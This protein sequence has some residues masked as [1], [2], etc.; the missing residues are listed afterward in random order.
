MVGTGVLLESFPFC[1]PL[2]T[3]LRSVVQRDPSQTLLAA[4]VLS[5]EQRGLVL[6]L[7]PYDEPPNAPYGTPFEWNAEHIEALGIRPAWK[8]SVERKVNRPAPP[9]DTL[10]H[11]AFQ[12]PRPVDPSD[13]VPMAPPIPQG[14]S[15]LATNAA[16]KAVQTSLSMAPDPTG[17]CVLL[18][19][20]KWKSK[21]VPPPTPASADAAA[22][23][24]PSVKMKAEPPPPVGLELVHEVAAPATA[25]VEG[26][27]RRPRL[28]KAKVYLAEG[29]HTTTQQSAEG[30]PVTHAHAQRPTTH[31]HPRRPPGPRHDFSPPRAAVHTLE[32]SADEFGAPP[33]TRQ[34]P[35]QQQ[36]QQQQRQ[37]Q[38]PPR[39]C[40][41]AQPTRKRATYA[42]GVRVGTKGTTIGPPSGPPPVRPQSAHALHGSATTASTAIGA[43]DAETAAL[44]HAVARAA[45]GAAA[46]ERAAELE[47]GRP[48]TM[49]GRPGATRPTATDAR[50]ARRGEPPRQQQLDGD[51]SSLLPAAGMWWTR[52]AK[53]APARGAHLAEL[54]EAEALAA[55]V[56]DAAD[57]D[58]CGEWMDAMPSRHS[59]PSQ[60][61]YVRLAAAMQA[62]QLGGGGGGGGRTAGGWRLVSG[63]ARERGTFGHEPR[64]S[65][66]SRWA[67]QTELPF[68]KHKGSDGA[69]AE[70]G[71]EAIERALPGSFLPLRVPTAQSRC[72]AAAARATAA[73]TRAVA[74]L[75]PHAELA[76]GEPPELQAVPAWVA[77]PAA[78][79]VEKLKVV[80]A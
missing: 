15:T 21:P 67:Y 50:R 41:T 3:A 39:C 63:A 76:Q 80:D 70:V 71:A 1:A 54:L 44:R 61:N 35:P 16:A 59:L 12:R 49:H 60:G 51:E 78:D 34:Q 65:A 46:A 64:Q 43:Y 72:E 42:L 28:A 66:S 77:P 29:V 20:A 56:V 32:W 48:A 7:L 47:L 9:Y 73:M 45:E 18:H 22:E 55:G 25:K 69:D 14:T 10:P 6:P 58:D 26:A 24:S 17:C 11:S 40:M 27:K 31:G 68:T 53:A 13:P 62:P 19:F 30:Q 57:G 4:Y 79:G 52:L 33:T 5:P 75:E 74:A 2:P 38:Q 36:Q 23:A 37:R 8:R